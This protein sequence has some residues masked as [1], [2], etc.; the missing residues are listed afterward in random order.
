MI[1]FHTR[2]A[3]PTTNG[4]IS[5]S[6][7]ASPNRRSVND[8]DINKA[9]EKRKELLDSISRIEVDLNKSNMNSI[10]SQQARNDLQSMKD[11][12]SRYNNVIVKWETGQS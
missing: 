10:E 11:A 1:F 6:G 7:Q 3:F 8:I 5:T 2:T 4:E 9:K 12:L